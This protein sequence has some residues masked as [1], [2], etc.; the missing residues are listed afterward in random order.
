MIAYCP[1]AQLR[2]MLTLLVAEK[3]VNRPTMGGLH[4]GTTDDFSDNESWAGPG[5]ADGDIMRGCL[6][7]GS[8]YHTPT[9][10]TNELSP[11]HTQLYWRFGSAHATG[12]QGV[13]VDGS[14]RTIR[15]GVNAV[16]FMR[17]CVRNDGQSFNASD[18]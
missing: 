1:I 5:F 3:L 10:D 14:V 17:V 13:F 8:T 15:Y 18:L 9:R 4:P 2:P 7:T 6:A 16:T 12:F 11:P